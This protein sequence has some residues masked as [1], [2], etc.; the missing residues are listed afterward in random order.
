M[1]KQT[2]KYCKNHGR[3]AAIGIVALFT[4]VLLSLYSQLQTDKTLNEGTGTEIKTETKG[5][6]LVGA[7]ILKNKCETTPTTYVV[8]G[9]N[10]NKVYA[11][12]A[13]T[14]CIAWRYDDGEGDIKSSVT[15]SGSTVL[16]GTE[17]NNLYALSLADGTELW[18]TE[19]TGKIFGAVAT[20]N[21]SVYVGD[22]NGSVSAYSIS[23]GSL[24][25]AYDGHNVQEDI[26]YDEDDNQTNKTVFAVDEYLHVGSIVAIDPDTQAAKWSF[27]AQS[28]IAAPPLVAE[29]GVYV[30][31]NEKILYKLN[32]GYGVAVWTF[33]AEK[34]IRSTP[35]MDEEGIL[36]FGSNDGYFYAVNSADG[37]LAWKYPVGS[38]VAAGAAVDDAYVYFGA[39][40]HKVY[41]VDK[42]T[43]LELWHAETGNKIQ[44]NL[45]LYNSILYVP[46][47][48]YSLYAFDAASG[49]QLWTYETKGALYGAVTIAS[50]S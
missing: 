44:G 3:N 2:K 41:A 15:V 46:S 1:K 36:Y 26:I 34:S 43:G 32:K 42:K 33:T 29:D 5:T 27:S 25:W 4:L 19:T 28:E 9:S 23:D 45:V 12:D 24:A 10:D 8:F 38:E 40:N 11:L 22:N 49:T 37:S 17:Q 13:E 39:Y 48:D 31:S 30:P 50:A 18:S 20:D 16:F 47:T 21:S 7:A 35:V 14:A 6:N